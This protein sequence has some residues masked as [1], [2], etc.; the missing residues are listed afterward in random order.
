M[1]I[2]KKLGLGIA[3]AA[4]GLSLIGGAT[5]AYFNDTAEVKAKFA[6]GTLDLNA[7][8]TTIINVGN[9]KPGDWMGKSFKLKNDGTL[10]ISKV[11]LSTNYVVTNK[12]GA[13]ANVGDLGEHIRVNFLINGTKD[14]LS[15]LY[16]TN[17]NSV[18]YSTTLA[19]LKAMT[20]DAV[21]DK[22]FL[23]F[24]GPNN[25]LEAGEENT[26]YV[27]YEFVNNGDQ[28]E[29]QGDSLELTWTFDGRQTAG[30]NRSN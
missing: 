8:P 13:P 10:D 19:Q 6:N 24:F 26:L 21:A 1:S 27:Q 20:P 4:L 15:I 18:I 3:S 7:A 29:F 30:E 9:L 2:K 5:Y 12:A 25:G 22:V 17:S 16:P 14:P 11:L 28:N 23:P